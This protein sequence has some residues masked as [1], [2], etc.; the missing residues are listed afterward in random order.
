VALDSWS[1]HILTISE[2]RLQSANVAAFR[3][4]G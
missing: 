1:A 3:P 2:G 4:R